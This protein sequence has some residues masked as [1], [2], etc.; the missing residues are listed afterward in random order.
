[1][2]NQGSLVRQHRGGPNRLGFAVQLAL[3]RFPG[4]VLDEET[5]VPGELIRWICSQIGGKESDWERYSGR[6]MTRWEHSAKAKSFHGLS[7]FTSADAQALVE[8]LSTVAL[9]ATKGLAVAE[10]AVSWLREAKIV[11]PAVSVIKRAC[12]EAMTRAERQVQELLCESLT[13]SHRPGKHRKSA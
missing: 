10:Y 12:A 9:H 5:V 7:A 8:E 13:D 3:F 4:I 6:A 2:R 1:M 11:L